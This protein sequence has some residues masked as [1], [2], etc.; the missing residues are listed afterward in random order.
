M[1]A[2]WPQAR[3]I[4]ASMALQPSIF[5][6]P[7]CSEHSSQVIWRPTIV[8]LNFLELL[9]VICYWRQ[10]PYFALDSTIHFSPKSLPHGASAPRIVNE[11]FLRSKLA[12]NAM[13]SLVCLVETF[14]F[15]PRVVLERIQVTSQRWSSVIEHHSASLPLYR[16]VMFTWVSGL[17]FVTNILRPKIT[18]Y[19]RYV[20]FVRERDQLRI[21]LRNEPRWKSHFLTS[22]LG[23]A[24][25]PHAEIEFRTKSAYVIRYLDCSRKDD[26]LLGARLLG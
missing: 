13:T 25:L 3:P 19:Q 8:D 10:F 11:C 24:S 1:P 4:A 14:C 12:A 16:V 22:S 7:G 9:A 23:T 20:K 5:R 21:E 15:L 6:K 26:L 17:Y 2:N 18:S